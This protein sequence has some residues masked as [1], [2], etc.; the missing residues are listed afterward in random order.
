MGK[1]GCT[2]DAIWE[3]ALRIKVLSMLRVFIREKD[4]KMNDV[5]T[6]TRTLPKPFQDP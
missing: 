1:D 6:A 2:I 4:K 5:M 3:K